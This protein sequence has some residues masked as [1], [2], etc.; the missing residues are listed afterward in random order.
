MD[1][2]ATQVEVPLKIKTT[3]NPHESKSR[4]LAAAVARLLADTTNEKSCNV[5]LGISYSSSMPA[6]DASGPLDR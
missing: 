6:A 3:S 1:A 2:T 4:A 5:V